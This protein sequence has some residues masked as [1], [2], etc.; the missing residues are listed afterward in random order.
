MFLVEVLGLAIFLIL[1]DDS[2]TNLLR[3][4]VLTFLGDHF[5]P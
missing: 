5:T 3:Y 1:H 2:I 4:T